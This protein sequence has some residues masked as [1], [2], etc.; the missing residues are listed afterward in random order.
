[1]GGR[2]GNRNAEEDGGCG[3]RWVEVRDGSCAL[4]G[5]SEGVRTFTTISESACLSVE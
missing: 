1:V 3:A 5:G 2:G 4:G